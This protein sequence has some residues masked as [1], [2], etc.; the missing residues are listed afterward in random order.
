MEIEPKKDSASQILLPDTLPNNRDIITVIL[1]LVQYFL[2]EAA[3][4]ILDVNTTQCTRKG[5]RALARALIQTEFVPIS[6]FQ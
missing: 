1:H 2:H 4:S 6:I 5:E 3:N